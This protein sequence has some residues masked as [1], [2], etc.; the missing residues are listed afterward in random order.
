ME[1][2]LVVF[3]EAS[4]AVSTIPHNPPAKGLVLQL[5]FSGGLTQASSPVTCFRYGLMDPAPERPFEELVER[6]AGGELEA[7]DETTDLARAEVDHRS[8][9]RRPLLRGVAALSVTRMPAR[10]ASASMERVMCRCQPCQ[11]RTSQSASPTSCLATSKH[12]S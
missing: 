1:T 6:D 10:K 9:P 2:W 4:D 11:E 3:R 5:S 7:A 12:S 8:R